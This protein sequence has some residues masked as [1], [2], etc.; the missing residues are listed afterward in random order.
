M[1]RIRKRRG[2]QIVKKMKEK[3]KKKFQDGKK[4]GTI[5]SSRDWLRVKTKGFPFISNEI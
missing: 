2:L 1:R 5:N 4:V 3:E